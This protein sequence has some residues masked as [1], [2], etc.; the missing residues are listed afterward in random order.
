MTYGPVQQDAYLRLAYFVDKI[1]KGTNPPICQLRDR[2]GSSS[3]S[4]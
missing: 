1:L 3:W 4:I 2:Q